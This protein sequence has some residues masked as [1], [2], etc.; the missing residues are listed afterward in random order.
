ML[1][2]Q[3]Q[4]KQHRGRR[5][6]R[7]QKVKLLP[8]ER[9]MRPIKPSK[10]IT[11]A[12]TRA[13]TRM[14]RQ[15]RAEIMEMY[16]NTALE[17]F[18]ESLLPAFEAMPWWDK[19]DDVATTMVAA[20]NMENQEAFYKAAN[21]SVGFNFRRFINEE[22]LDQVMTSAIE[23]NVE[24]ISDLEENSL[25]RIQREV[26]RALIE[27]TGKTV[28]L[29]RALLK[30]FTTDINQAKFIARDQ[31]QRYM[32]SLNKFRQQKA[33]VK[34]YKW[35]TSSDGRVRAS[36]RA[37]NGEIFFWSRPDPVTG[38]PGHDYNC[39]CTASPILEVA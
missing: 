22:G 33:G 38:H 29:R 8:N 23:E 20:G 10:K 24:A 26:S 9:V 17:L 13:T 25:R 28:G 14:V 18:N 39:R 2:V 36:H 35:V 27:Q 31:T 11:K 15:T 37:N 3:L 32:N 4:D 34:K 16:S 21:E 5:R 30:G 7:R 1:S 12:Y 6:K 19:A